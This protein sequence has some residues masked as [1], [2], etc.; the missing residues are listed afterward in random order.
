MSRAGKLYT[1]DRRRLVGDYLR[2]GL[3]L[4]ITAGPVVV[5]RLNDV[6]AIILLA[7][8]SLCAVLM[9]QTAYRHRQRLHVSPSG[10]CILPG[11]GEIPWQELAGLRLGYYSTRRDGERGWMQ[12]NLRSDL[13][14]LV[15]DSRLVGFRELVEQAADAA[16]RNGLCLDAATRENLRG[17]NL[18][19]AEIHDAGLE[20]G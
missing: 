14:R 10:I 5:L 2:C 12:L 1:Y 8:G 15:V 20:V 11:G 18:P 17:L 4:L 16:H 13:V 19:V 7:I 6:V 9:V 3:G